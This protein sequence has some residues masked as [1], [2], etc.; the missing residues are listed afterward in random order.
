MIR[1][2]IGYDYAEN[3]AHNVMVNSIQRHASQPVAIAQVALHQLNDVLWR[4]RHPL[5]SNDFAFS[6]WLVPYLC[7]YK[8]WA[9]WADCDMLFFDDVAKLWAQRNQKYAVQVVKHEHKP[10]ESKKYLGTTQTAYDKKNWSSVMLFN[11]EK[12]RALTP[13][14]INNA[15]GLHLHQFKWLE[16]DNLIGEISPEWNYLVG[17]QKQ[18]DLEEPVRNAHFTIGGPYFREYR[19]TEF[20]QEWWSEYWDMVNCDDPTEPPKKGYTK[21]S[22]AR[23]ADD[24]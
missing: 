4:E 23:G 6:R 10:K 22:E 12:C 1:M 8:G 24:S 15:D 19:G 3:V 20:A 18:S 17:Y 11:C 21:G 2:F 14:L 9:I 7:N 5:Q 13:G 16:N